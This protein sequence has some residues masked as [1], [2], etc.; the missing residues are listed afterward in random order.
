MP[1]WTASCCFPSAVVG[2]VESRGGPKEAD[3]FEEVLRWRVRYDE[4][5]GSSDLAGA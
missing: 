2:G 4:E 1:S 3:R 5:R